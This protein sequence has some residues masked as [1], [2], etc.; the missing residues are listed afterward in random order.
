MPRQPPIWRFKSFGGMMLD[1][2]IEGTDLEGGSVSESL[3]VLS[4]LLM[5]LLGMEKP[6]DEYVACP[7]TAS[8]ATLVVAVPTR[9]SYPT[10]TWHRW[11]MA[12]PFEPLSQVHRGQHSRS[13]P[14]PHTV[15]R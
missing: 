2:F 6:E 14:G 3:A 11:R 4:F 5:R 7:C 8:S 15:P 13:A 12:Y 1:P 9:S 10:D